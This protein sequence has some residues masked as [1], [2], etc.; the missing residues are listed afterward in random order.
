M[1]NTD[2]SSGIPDRRLMPGCA[3]LVADNRVPVHGHVCG[4]AIQFNEVFPP[5]RR[6][7]NRLVARPPLGQRMHLRALM[8]AFACAATSTSAADVAAHLV[9]HG[10]DVV[11]PDGERL[12]RKLLA[13]VESCSVNSTSSAVP[14][15][16]WP[17]MAASDSFLHVVFSPPRLA[18]LVDREG[19]R[20]LPQAVREVLLPLPEGAWPAHVFVKTGRGTRSFTKYD[21]FVL[22]DLISE[23]GL[24][25]LSVAPYT[26]LLV[27]PAR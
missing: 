9:R 18:L 5:S 27:P 1:E 7:A 17:R 14:E 21:P 12:A 22:R 16:D 8:I 25:L 6:R 13:V 11:T 15:S 10:H 3:R 4:A 26:Q 20:R 24:Q 2:R 23:P 19:Q